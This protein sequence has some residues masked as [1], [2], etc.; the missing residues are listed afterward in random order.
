MKQNLKM[1]ILVVDDDIDIRNYISAVLKKNGFT[2]IHE[3]VDG[4]GAVDFLEQSFLEN[5]T[6][7]MVLADWQMPEVD[8]IHLL[9]YLKRNSDFSNIPFLM[10]T[11]DSDRYHIVEAINSGVSQYLIKPFDEKKLLTKIDEALRQRR[12]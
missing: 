7:D 2:N 11:S 10:V 8:G 9:N 5:K 1:S 4:V 6:V 3:E 12:A